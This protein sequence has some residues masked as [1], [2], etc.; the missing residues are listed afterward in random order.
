MNMWKVNDSDNDDVD[1]QQTY[2]DQKSSCELKQKPLIVY[3]SSS[4]KNN[5]RNIECYNFKINLKSANVYLL[6]A[7][8]TETALSLLFV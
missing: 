5:H 8:E 3:F 7:C 2:S 4:C 1:R 6:D